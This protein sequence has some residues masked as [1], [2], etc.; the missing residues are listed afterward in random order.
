MTVNL[1]M[2]RRIAQGE[3]VEAAD[4]ALAGIVAGA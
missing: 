3:E 4:G 2:L 1:R